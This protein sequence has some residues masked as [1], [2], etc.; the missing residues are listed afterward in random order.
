MNYSI[1]YRGPLSSCNYG[2]DYCP[3]AKTKNTRVELADDQ[4]KLNRFISWIEQHPQH[5]FGILFTPWGEALIRNYYQ[6]AIVRLSNLSNVGKVAIQ[7]NM[8][9]TTEWLL[10]VNKNT[11]ALWT[12]YHPT[13][14][15]LQSFVRKCKELDTLG[16][17][18]SV[19]MVGF[20]DCIDEIKK[21]RAQLSPDVYVWINAYKRQIDYYSMEDVEALTQI[22]HL[23]EYNRKY[24]SSYGKS[25]RTGQSVFSLDGDG[26]MYRCHFI[27]TRIGNIYNDNFENNLFSR[28]CVNQTCGCHIGYVHM[29]DLHLDRIFGGGELERIP[30]F[31]Q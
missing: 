28:P 13:Q 8:S 15:T 10:E 18:Y 31:L 19:G 11:T 6:Q 29:Q 9:C 23:F 30:K 3:F 21:L 5:N 16:V 27:K 22:D 26:N 25:C 7:T 24:H 14:T 20:K 1:L 4:R 17:R 12:T 2:C